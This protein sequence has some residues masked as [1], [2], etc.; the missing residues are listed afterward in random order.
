MGHI[1]FIGKNYRFSKRFHSILLK[2]DNIAEWV[3][4]F[5]KDFQNLGLLKI[6]GKEFTTVDHGVVESIFQCL[7]VDSLFTLK[8]SNFII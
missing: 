4:S 6:T 3:I 5:G 8:F 7:L 1:Q 2:Q